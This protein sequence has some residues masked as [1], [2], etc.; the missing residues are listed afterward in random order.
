MLAAFGGGAGAVPFMPAF[1]AVA[2]PFIAAFGG[3][4][5]AAGGG[6]VE[7]PAALG[8]GEAETA[9]AGLGDCFPSSAS[10]VCALP[11]SGRRSE[12]MPRRF[13]STFCATLEQKLVDIGKDE[14]E[15][16]GK[17]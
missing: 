2:V 8:A 15:V 7:F 10:G 12:S 14:I 1:G 11:P 17:V 4:C 16:S 13:R 3:S 9:E 6:A 5:L